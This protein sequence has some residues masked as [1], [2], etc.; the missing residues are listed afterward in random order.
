MVLVAG[1]LIAGA[2]IVAMVL[3]G[4]ATSKSA[5]ATTATGSTGSTGATGPAPAGIKV[6]G[7][8]STDAA[9]A[10]DAAAAR[11]NVPRYVMYGMFD[12]ETSLGA[13][14]GTSSTGAMGPFQ[15]EPGT[16]AGYGYPMTNTPSLAQFQQQADSAAHYLSDLFRQEGNSWTTALA[17]Y[18]AGPGNTSAGMGYAARAIAAGQRLVGTAG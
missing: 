1:V 10:I 15:F 13:G 18:N 2:A 11:Y 5:A 17:A 8:S 3:L 14:M 4:G 16:A 12:V 6:P 7:I 9:A